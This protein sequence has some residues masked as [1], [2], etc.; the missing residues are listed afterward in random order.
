MR[1]RVE[2]IISDIKNMFIR[3]METFILEGV[4]IKRTLFS[5]GLQLNKSIK[6]QLELTGNL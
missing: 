3:T 2:T 4:L 6:Q 1:K 5:F